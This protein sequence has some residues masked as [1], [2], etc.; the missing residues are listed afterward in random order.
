MAKVHIGDRFKARHSVGEEWIVEKIR[1]GVCEL[2]NV[3]EP[4]ILRF[5]R[6]SKLLDGERYAPVE[7]RGSRGGRG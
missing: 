7:T 3:E 6:I 1:N 4:N 5:H 2:H